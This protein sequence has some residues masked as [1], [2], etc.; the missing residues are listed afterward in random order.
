MGMWILLESVHLYHRMQCPLG[1]EKASELKL[2]TTMS[3][4]VGDGNWTLVLWEKQVGLLTNNHP[5][6][7]PQNLYL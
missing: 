5:L 1:P 6:K 2:Q 4:N 3:H 7:K